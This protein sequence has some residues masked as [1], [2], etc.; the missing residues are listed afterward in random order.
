MIT[1]FLSLLVTL[2]ICSA[3][4]LYYLIC[5]GRLNNRIKLEHKSHIEK[6]ESELSKK[7]QAVEESH[8][9]ILELKAQ[10]LQSQDILKKENL[11]KSTLEKKL[12]ALQAQLE[13]LDREKEE[14]S[15]RLKNEFSDKEKKLNAQILELKDKLLQSE[16]A[17]KKENVNKITLEKKLQELQGQSVRLNKDLSLKTQMYDGLKGQY[18]ELERDMEKLQ[19][20]LANINQGGYNKNYS[21]QL[22]DVICARCGIKTQVPFKP[23]QGR[24]VYCRLCY[25]SI[26]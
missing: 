18:D 16:D 3:I 15:T 8:K 12:Q 10:L 14:F 22:F 20:E 11:N 7:D 17:L 23:V 4:A 5:K 26:K 2:A 25:Q 9:Q 6:L 21:K 1:M 19:Q 13:R 24:S